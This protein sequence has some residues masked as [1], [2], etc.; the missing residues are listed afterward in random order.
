MTNAAEPNTGA[1]IF[2]G[3]LLG[4]WAFLAIGLSGSNDPEWLYGGL[5]ALAIAGATYAS[6]FLGPEAKLPVAIGIGLLIGFAIMGLLITGSFWS[7]GP[8]IFG[9]VLALLG[10]TVIVN[11]IPNQPHEAAE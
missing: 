8:G 10:A 6:R 5:I 9:F 1:L 11:G 2:G 3:I 4:I 7:M